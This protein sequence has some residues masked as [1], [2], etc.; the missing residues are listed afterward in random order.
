MIEAMETS[1]HINQDVVA[2]NRRKKATLVCEQK[3]R[4]VVESQA[5]LTESIVKLILE[6]R[7]S[8]TVL[9]VIRTLKQP[10]GHCFFLNPNR[11]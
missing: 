3:Y 9:N 11:L 4:V 10:K 1:S 7:T 8:N 2:S 5:K 6:F